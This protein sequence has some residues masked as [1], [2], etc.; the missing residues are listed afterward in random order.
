M[1]AYSISNAVDTVHREKCEA[2]YPKI[3]PKVKAK[4]SESVQLSIFD[5]EV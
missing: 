1:A 4:I 3:A 5:M 2:E